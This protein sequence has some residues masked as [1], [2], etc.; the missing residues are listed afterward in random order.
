M[1]DTWCIVTGT[2][3]IP[4]YMPDREN[5]VMID[6]GLKRP[7]REGILSLL[8]AEKIRVSAVLTSHFHRDHTGNHRA[9]REKFGAQVFM[10]PFASAM[11]NDPSKPAGFYESSLV[12]IIRD[13]PVERPP[14]QLFS[15]KADSVIAAGYDF[16]ILPLPGH[17]HEHVGFVTPDGVAY[18]GDTILSKHI[19]QSI[20]IPY[21]T[22][23]REDFEAKASVLQMDYS[24][25]VLA[26]S[27]VYS[28]VR[29]LAQENIDNMHSK[30]NMVESFAHSYIT[31]ERLSA[32]I[33]RYTGADGDSLIRTI[34]NKRNV[35]VLVEYLQEVGRLTI[36]AKDGYVEY[37]STSTNKE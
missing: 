31:L 29:E 17:A 2:G 22:F 23:C 37:I 26:H 15:A 16:R 24:C 13:T 20:R 27:G 4:V 8:E 10:T 11:Y 33:L 12:D 6:S 34:G 30:L 25:Y 21:C 1:A 14:E 35:Q 3:R 36:R 32:E 18:L 19:L 7:D 9:I 5:A 28:E